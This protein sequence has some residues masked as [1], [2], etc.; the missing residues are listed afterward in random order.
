MYNSKALSFFLLH[1][2]LSNRYNIDFI[3]FKGFSFICFFV[4]FRCCIWHRIRLLVSHVLWCPVLLF[5]LDFSLLFSSLS[6]LFSSPIT[7]NYCRLTLEERSIEFFFTYIYI[8][9]IICSQWPLVACKPT[10]STIYEIRKS[11]KER[12]RRRKRGKEWRNVDVPCKFCTYTTCN[13]IQ[14][15]I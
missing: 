6:L 15:A 3:D 12:R 14:N 1:I 13:Q 2:S 7:I 8:Y 10:S 9:I 5:K 11:N 4:S